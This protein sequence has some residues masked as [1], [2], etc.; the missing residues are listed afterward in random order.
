MALKVDF[1]LEKTLVSVA[2]SVLFFL[3]GRAWIN[4]IQA[5][6]LRSLSS[7]AKSSS[8]Q[9]KEQGD[10]VD[11]LFV[12]KQLLRFKILLYLFFFSQV[13]D[14]V[15]SGFVYVLNLQ[16]GLDYPLKIFGQDPELVFSSRFNAEKDL[17][18]KVEYCE[19]F[20]KMLF[21]YVCPIAMVL[22]IL[23]KEFKYATEQSMIAQ[24]SDWDHAPRE[25][26]VR[27]DQIRGLNF[28]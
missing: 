23:K 12:L 4:S 15:K 26:G 7:F 3:V 8:Y 1:L 16:S 13:Y 20:F 14:A 9:V 19:Y 25:K 6:I 2:V 22:T 27:G 10:F 28:H 24:T 18:N 21:C 5:Q 17:F 11:Q